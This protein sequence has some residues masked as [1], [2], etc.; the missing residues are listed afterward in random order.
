MNSTLL[1]QN[2]IS[3]LLND[4]FRQTVICIHKVQVNVPVLYTTCMTRY[5]QLIYSSYVCLNV[6]ELYDFLS[7]YTLD[8]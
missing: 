2:M 7:T 6:L 4:A 8:I 3:H 5:E 1:L